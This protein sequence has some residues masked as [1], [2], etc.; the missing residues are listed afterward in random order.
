MYSLF[1]GETNA[2]EVEA[3]S[4]AGDYNNS[5]VYML[6]AQFNYLIWPFIV[7]CILNML[8]MLNIWKRSRKMSH[9][10]VF[11]QEVK[12]REEQRFSSPAGT[13]K[14]LE[15][16]QQR[17]SILSRQK[18]SSTERCPSMIL[19]ENETAPAANQLPSFPPETK[20]RRSSNMYERVELETVI[21]SLPLFS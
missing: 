1:D 14:E 3:N 11:N 5:F 20:R 13:S 4:C 15:E 6:I 16:D 18:R 7:V 17:L 12:T 10:T 9:C 19:E 21:S 2:T 8:L